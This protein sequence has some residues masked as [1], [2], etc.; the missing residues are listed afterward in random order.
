[1][2]ARF[3]VFCSTLK[4]KPEMYLE[5]QK[6]DYVKRYD[7]YCGPKKILNFQTC[8]HWNKLVEKCHH[9]YLSLIQ[10]L[11]DGGRV[12]LTAPAATAGDDAEEGEHPWHVGLVREE[13]KTGVLG[14]IRLHSFILTF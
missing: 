13:S 8:P 7:E 6:N 1:M 14:W 4:C 2:P 9:I 10:A 5:T 11:R 3:K 12:S